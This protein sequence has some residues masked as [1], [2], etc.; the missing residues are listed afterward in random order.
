MEAAFAAASRLHD[1]LPPAHLEVT[2]PACSALFGY[3][4]DYLVLAGFG[5]NRDE[6]EY[7]RTRIAGILDRATDFL[8]DTAAAEAYQRLRDLVPPSA[9][10]A[11]RLAVLPAA[12]AACLATIQRSTLDLDG[13]N[14]V[15][16]LG[17]R[18]LEFCAHAGAGVAEISVNR[19][20]AGQDASR[21]IAQWRIAARAAGGHLR[22]TAI[23]QSLRGDVPAFD[24]P[25]EG[26]MK[27][28]RRLKASFDPAGIFNPGCF[29][30]GI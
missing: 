10:A 17:E 23:A 15:N 21:L 27:L 3:P 7:Q 12:M 24:S 28:M 20:L 13:T 2:S 18:P 30:G 25:S 22:L 8:Q 6:M 29:V 9:T 19:A 5:G 26:A 11:A 14:R 1:A 4:R 16:K